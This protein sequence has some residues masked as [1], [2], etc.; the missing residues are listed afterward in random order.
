MTSRQLQALEALL[1]TPTKSAAAERAGISISTLR[2]YLADE[3]FARAYHDG[4]REILDDATHAAQKAM[5]G[6]VCVLDQI[7]K[8]PKSSG[9][10][11]VAAARSLLE[12]GL[13]LTEQLDTAEK[14]AD[15]ERAVKAM[16]WEEDD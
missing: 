13:K 16:G 10:V 5:T 9:T 4:L 12:F 8:N 14:L 2:N 1:S 7:C 11:R 3:E 6:A 15:I